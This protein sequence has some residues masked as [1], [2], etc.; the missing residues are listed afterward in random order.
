MWETKALLF[1]K[2]ATLTIGKIW[3]VSKTVKNEK[4]AISQIRH[5]FVDPLKVLIL[6]FVSAI[7]ERHLW[8][9]G[10]YVNMTKNSNIRIR[11]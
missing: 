1:S 7:M 10:W 5:I 11:P 3:Y 8:Q 9:N 6:W 4:K 2:N